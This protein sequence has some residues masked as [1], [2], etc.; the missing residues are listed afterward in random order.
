MFYMLAYLIVM[1]MC[2]VVS[3]EVVESY[4][5]IRTN[6]SGQS[7]LN[8]DDWSYLFNYEFQSIITYSNTFN[9]CFLGQ[10]ASQLEAELHAATRQVT[11]SK[12]IE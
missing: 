1:V 6:L 10:M 12:I 11:P 3:P 4:F 7:V 8:S 9:T 5:T 2:G